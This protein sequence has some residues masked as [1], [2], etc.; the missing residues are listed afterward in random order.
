[1]ERQP[2]FFTDVSF[3]GSAAARDDDA[4]ALVSRA[5][6]VAG[7]GLAAVILHGSWVRGAATPASDVDALV[8]VD[9]RIAVTRGLYRTWDSQRVTWRGRTVDPH[10]VHPPADETFSGLWAEAAIEGLV[11]FDR[12][13]RLPAYLA[14]VRR[15]IADGRLVRRV[16]HG[17]PYWTEAA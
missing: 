4:V 2:G 10:F 15:A 16:V 8:V 5:G 14:R 1:M 6:A 11:L 12:E 7:D 13:E 3:L 9:P 17:Q